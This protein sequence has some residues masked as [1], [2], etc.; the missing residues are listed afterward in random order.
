MALLIVVYMI[1][2]AIS[3]PAGGTEFDLFNLSL[4]QLAEIVTTGD[5]HA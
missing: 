4:R 2:T 5:H 3:F 1:L